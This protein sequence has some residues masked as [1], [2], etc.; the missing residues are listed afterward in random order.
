LD[1]YRLNVGRYPSED[2]GGLGALLVR[3]QYENERLT[4][5]WQGPYL[6]RGAK[7]EDPWGNPL[8]Y[9]VVDRSLAEDPGAPAYRL[10]SV[11]PDGQPDT[12]DDIRLFEEEESTGLDSTTVL[13]Q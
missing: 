5:K 4:E 3:P 1:T 11:G 9:E 2:E 6:K 12:E 7:L 10:Y 13:E 8:H